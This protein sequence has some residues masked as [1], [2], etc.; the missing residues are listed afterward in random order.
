[1]M[2]CHS[3][4]NRIGQRGN[5]F[6]PVSNVNIA[7]KPGTGELTGCR[8]KYVRKH[9]FLPAQTHVPG[10]LGCVLW[11]LLAG[12]GALPLVK[13]RGVKKGEGLWGNWVWPFTTHGL[14]SMR[15]E[16]G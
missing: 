15:L 1:M 10:D 6:P 7:F 3:S 4:L 2:F 14:Q 9:H 13:G 5:V 11:G 8:T 12:P 16:I